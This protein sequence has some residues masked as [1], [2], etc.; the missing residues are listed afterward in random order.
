MTIDR[1]TGIDRSFQT[2]EKKSNANLKQIIPESRKKFMNLLHETNT[3][4][5]L[6]LKKRI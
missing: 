3:I 1:Q 4:L 5:I 6:K 2:F